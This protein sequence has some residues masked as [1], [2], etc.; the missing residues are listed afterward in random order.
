M[1]ACVLTNQSSQKLKQNPLEIKLKQGSKKRGL[2]M[3]PCD[4][5]VK[6]GEAEREDHIGFSLCNRR[7]GQ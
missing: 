4:E 7:W 2:H 1:R 5:D 3:V 6:T